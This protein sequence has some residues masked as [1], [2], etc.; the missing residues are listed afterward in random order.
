[1]AIPNPTDSGGFVNNAE[2][3][4]PIKLQSLFK[5]Y[6]DDSF[7]T[8]K[9]APIWAGNLGP[10]LRAEVGDTLHV[11]FKNNLPA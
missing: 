10:I 11:H 5:E 1:M 3:A 4:M 2:P 9:E 6:T 7:T 8:P